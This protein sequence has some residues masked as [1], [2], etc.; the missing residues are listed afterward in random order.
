MANKLQKALY[1][2]NCVTSVSDNN[3][4]NEFIVQST[5]VLAEANMNLRM[6]CW[7][8]FEVTNQDVTCNV[9]IEQDVN[10][11]I[12]V[13][14]LKWD[15]T[16]D[17]LVITPKLEAKLESP[18][19]RKILSLTQGIFD[20]LGFLAPSLLPA[21]LLV[22]QAW[23]TKSDWD[24][25]LPTDIQTK[26]M[27]WLDELKEL[28]KIKIPRRLG[29]GSP[30]HWTL[31]VFC[32]AS[33]DAYAAVIF[34]RSDNQGEIILRFVGS[35]SRVSPLKRLTILRLE[36]LACLLGARFAKYIVE[37]LDIPLKALT[38]W[39]DSTTTIS[40]IQRNDK[41][42]TFVGNRVKEILSIT[43][44]SQWS[45]I[46]GKLNPADLASRGCT[47]RQL[48][49][50]RW[51]EGPAFR[52][53]PPESWTNCESIADEASVNSEL[54]KEKVLD[55]T[56]KTEV[57]EWFEKFSNFSKIIRVLCWVLR[58]VDNTRKN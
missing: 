10:P 4:L 39:S 55:L 8:P 38:F 29:Y 50:S 44:S 12:P 33:L 1:V 18:T 43:E 21:K 20:P 49:R 54:K 41:W 32:D 30:D 42:G 9:N 17:T 45:Y 23:A 28:S 7:G 26:Y 6:W 58:F 47:P 25:P 36:L 52:K 22:Q 34:L 11:V 15:R 37:A 31:H 3:E 56:V 35:K 5:N 46:P 48:L 51:W 57:R 14:G 24:T 19:K 2:D 13:L 27:Q 16:D 40:W 53:G